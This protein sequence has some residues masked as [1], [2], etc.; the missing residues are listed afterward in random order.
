[1]SENINELR[2]LAA[3][4]LDGKPFPVLAKANAPKLE[5]TNNSRRVLSQL[6]FV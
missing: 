5:I 3:P 1:V 2:K 4:S 6:Q